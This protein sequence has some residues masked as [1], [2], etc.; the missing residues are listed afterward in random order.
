M[1]AQ[2]AMLDLISHTCMCSYLDC[3]SGWALSMRKIPEQVMVSVHSVSIMRWL[4]C[5][6]LSPQIEIIWS[7]FLGFPAMHVHW[8]LLPGMFSVSNPR[9]NEI[10]QWQHKLHDTRHLCA[11]YHS[12]ADFASHKSSVDDFPLVHAVKY[13]ASVQLKPLCSE[14]GWSPLPT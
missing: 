2:V 12:A 13:T 9:T 1:W 5:T 11:Q 4:L 7:F 14:T 8:S 6:L 3:M 10:E